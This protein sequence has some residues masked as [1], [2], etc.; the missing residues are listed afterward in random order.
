MGTV[1]QRVLLLVLKIH[2]GTHALDDAVDP[3]RVHYVNE[4]SHCRDNLD[5]RK[6]GA[7]DAG[8]TVVTLK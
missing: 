3:L 2:C 7:G 1:P 5:V 6:L 4:S 8:V